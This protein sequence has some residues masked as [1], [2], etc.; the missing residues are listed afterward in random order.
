M[1]VEENNFQDNL[2]T[3]YIW[4]SKLFDYKED[5]RARYSQIDWFE[6]DKKG[7]SLTDQFFAQPIRLRCQTTL[8]NRIFE[9]EKKKKLTFHQFFF[10]V[11]VC[12][13]SGVM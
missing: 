5:L 12:F 11:L 3:T 2:L 8:V 9:E 10:Q 13:V 1:E 4:Y 6:G 7:D